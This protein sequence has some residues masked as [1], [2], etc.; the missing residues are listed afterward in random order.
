MSYSDYKI[1][2][3]GDANNLTRKISSALADG[4]QV[5]GPPN[6]QWGSSN[7]AQAVVKGSAEG[8]GGGPVTVDAIA[9]AGTAGKDILKS[10]TA[11]DGQKALG[12]VETVNAVSAIGRPALTE[13]VRKT[14]LT[15]IDDDVRAETY[16]YWKRLADETGI[17]I[18][19]AVVPNWVKGNS[20]AGKAAMSLA[21]LREM[22]DDGHDLASHGYDTLTIQENLDKPDVL[23][24]QLHDAR[25]WMIE[26]GFTRDSCYDNFVWPQGLSGDALTQR[27]AKSEVRKYYRYAVNAF[28]ANKYIQPGVFDSYD[29]SRPMADGQTAAAITAWLDSA[30]ARKGWMIVG[31]HAWHAVDQDGGNYDTWSAR[32]RALIEHAKAKGVEIVTLSQGLKLRGNASSVG[33]WLDAP[34]CCYINN[35][36][37]Q[38]PAIFNFGVGGVAKTLSS[39]DTLTLLKTLGTGYYAVNAPAAD[40]PNKTY[41]FKL[42]WTLTATSGG[43]HGILVAT[44]ISAKSPMYRNRLAAGVWGG[45]VK[46]WDT[47]NTTT[48]AN[49]FIKAASPIV[50]LCN[51]PDKMAENFLADGFTLSG[52]G[53]VNGE[54]TGVSV[55]R[56][57]VGVYKVTGS[58]GLATEGW[59]IEVPQ[60]VNGNRLCFVEI[61]VAAKSSDITV[62]VSNRRFDAATATIV[63]GDPM[64][65]PDGRWVDLR[66]Q[67]PEPPVESLSADA[68][69]GSQAPA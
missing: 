42:D 59:T 32:Y 3:A 7:L 68:V 1:I 50:R 46:I 33:E 2:V 19:L 38:Y 26:N 27:R 55:E 53:A 62:K 17:K 24:T 21:Q 5:Y 11:A 29:M 56:V 58:L 43:G 35:D 51:A 54:A 69:D 9:D 45:W 40:M 20:P 23:H 37:S 49:G 44:E 36:G 47:S 39:T 52:F 14:F 31:S 6:L 63:A 18:T 12:L 65:I 22:Y 4:Y 57:S 60:D 41:A 67:M 8:G 28:S 15:F 64:D 16:T 10:T 25:Q 30:I 48:D 66:L 61:S 13:P 34:N